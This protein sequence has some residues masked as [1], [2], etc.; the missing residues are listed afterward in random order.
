M[1]EKSESAIPAID[2]PDATGAGAFMRKRLVVIGAAFAAMLVAGGS[3]WLA[4]NALSTGA[5]RMNLL[6]IRTVTFSGVSGALKR[7]DAGDLN[8]IAGAIR[9][10]GGSMLHTD[11]N[12]V[13]A[14]V[15]QVEWVRSAEV[16]RRFPDT[17]EVRIEEHTPFARW[18]VASEAEQSLLVNV[19]GEVFE[20]E[21]DDRLPVFGGPK[22]SAREV[23]TNYFAFK[24][25]LAAIQQVPSEVRLSP[26]RAWQLKLENG[27]TLELGRSDA[28][29]RLAR[30]VR[31][32][33]TIATLQTANT[34]VDLRYQTGLAVRVAAAGATAGTTR[35]I[36]KKAPVKS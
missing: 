30:Y 23:M 25:Q 33:P 16:R 28:A 9:N 7:V 26:R 14:A 12:Q 10:M 20:A 22:D 13:K 29:M 6:P 11:L 8:R 27:G 1:T 3:A 17:L 36:T 32:F 18:Q 24:S 35:T 5:V 34:R 4:I 15:S 19:L 2:A 21:L 31:A